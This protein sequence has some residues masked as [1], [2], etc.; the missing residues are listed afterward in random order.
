MAAAAS[1]FDRNKVMGKNFSCPVRYQKLR[2]LLELFS[3][4]SS[5]IWLQQLRHMMKSIVEPNRQ[6]LLYPSKLP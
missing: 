3:R 2:N 5:G 4:T 6:N 1:D